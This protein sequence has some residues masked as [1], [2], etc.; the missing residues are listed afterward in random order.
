[1]TDA[2]AIHQVLGSAE[3]L[4]KALEPSSDALLSQR[5]G[6]PTLFSSS[7]TSSYWRFFRKGIAPAFVQKNIKCAVAHV[8]PGSS[9]G[10]CRQPGS[11]R[12]HQQV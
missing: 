8:C 5:R 9:R 12:V 4:D 11:K 10:A 2:Y 1:M 7:T 6:H 3:A